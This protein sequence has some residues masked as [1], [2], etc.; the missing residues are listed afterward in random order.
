MRILTAFVLLISSCAVIPKQHYDIIISDGL[1]YDGSGGKP[2]NAD[3]GIKGDT[4]AFVGDL[5]KATAK[6][7]ID[8]KGKAVAPGFINMLSWATETLIKDGRSMGDIRQGVTLEVFGEGWSMGPLNEKMK[9]D[10]IN[11]QTFFKYDVNWNT[12]GGYLQMLQDKGVSPNVAS[13]VGATTI[14]I[15]VIGEDN[16]DPTN[17]ELEQMKLLVKQAME[18]GALGIGSSLIYPPAFFAKTSELLN[19]ARL[20][21]NTAACI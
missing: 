13:F 3:I 16:R 20:L 1:I 15:H 7:N 18:E 14:R 6:E 21:L 17:T 9:Q 19:Y 5:S 10:L 11:D 8:A 4:I 2:F 12:L